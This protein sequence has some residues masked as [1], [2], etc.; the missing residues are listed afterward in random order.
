MSKN[1]LGPN[2]LHSRVKEMFGFIRTKMGL[3]TLFEQV[4]QS[5]KYKWKGTIGIVGLDPNA[6]AELNIGIVKYANNVGLTEDQHIPEIISVG[7]PTKDVRLL[8]SQVELCKAMGADVIAFPQETKSS[9]ISLNLQNRFK[10]PVH[11]ITNNCDI[12]DLAKITLNNAMDI[13]YPIRPDILFHGDNNDMVTGIQEDARARNKRIDKIIQGYG[14]FPVLSDPFTGIIGGAGPLA[15]AQLSVKL[16][17]ERAPFVHVSANSAPG[18]HLYEIQKGPSYV[19]TYASIYDFLRKIGSYN[20]VVPCNTAHMRLNE[21]SKNNTSSIIDIRKSVMDVNINEAGFI[22]LGT[23]RTV[24]VNCNDET[25]LYEQLRHEYPDQGPFYVPSEEQQDKIMEAI[26]DV[27]A[28]KLEKAKETIFLITKS[29]RERYGDIKVILGCTELPLVFTTLE[30]AEN[31]FIDPAQDMAEMAG[32]D[33]EKENVRR[34]EAKHSPEKTQAPS[35]NNPKE[36]EA[37]SKTTK[38]PI[39]QKPNTTINN[40]DFKN[41]DAKS[42]IKSVSQLSNVQGNDQNNSK[43]GL[44]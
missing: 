16:A 44:G 4:P 10:I 36:E 24:G 8:E 18:K 12:D 33:L 40:H 35:E 26:F 32:K 3:P 5:S 23:N 37:T 34:D 9:N 28:G 38:N 20:I 7:V 13:Q 29:L 42:S 6:V 39:E 14:G 43:G 17:K 41:K 21:F 27:K 15:S 25:G 2:L 30:L 1:R 22:L 11:S 31:G 19:P